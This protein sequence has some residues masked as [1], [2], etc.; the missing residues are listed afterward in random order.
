MKTSPIFFERHVNFNNRQLIKASEL[1][2]KI[3]Q[4]VQHNEN[5][6]SKADEYYKLL[7]KIA[8]P[9]TTTKH[10]LL[11]V[12]NGKSSSCWNFEKL[13]ILTLMSKWAHDNGVSKE[14]KEA[15]KWFSTAVKHEL[16][17]ILALNNYVWKDPDISMLHILQYRYH[18]AKALQFASDYYYNMY[19][20]KQV[21]SPIRMSYQL[22]EIASR[23]WKKLEY[24]QLNRR[25]ALTLKH[26]AESLA[27]DDCGQKV[28]LLEQALE[29]DKSEE[30]QTTFDKF[31]DDNDSVYYKDV[32]TE[33][34]ISCLSLED[35]FQSLLSIAT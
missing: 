10:P 18:L 17:A 22:M 35:S 27:D 3:A 24:S 28:A 34:T 13:H 14:P 7:S 11:F 6:Y 5:M 29:L 9:T 21:L 1:R 4:G 12:W 33:L 2:R 16:Q 19:T 30:I 32:K 25:Y 26:L 31:K 15:K 23:T 8:V 20:F